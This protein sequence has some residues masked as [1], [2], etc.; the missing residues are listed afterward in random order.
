ML[1]MSLKPDYKDII[2][3]RGSLTPSSA[4]LEAP[5]ADL[6]E[7]TAP[8]GPPFFSDTDDSSVGRSRK[9]VPKLL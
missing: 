5:R 6:K 7:A 9:A 2:K 4:S 8:H 1:F 3:V